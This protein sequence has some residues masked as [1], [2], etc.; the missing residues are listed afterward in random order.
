MKYLRR[1]YATVLFKANTQQQNNNLSQNTL[2]KKSLK[3]REDL[4][5]D[6]LM[7][8]KSIGAENLLQLIKNYSKNDGVKQAVT[9]G[10]IGFPNVGKSSLINR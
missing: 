7:S 2:Y 4:T 8:N 9:V 1:E 3:D 6:L 10:V 5:H